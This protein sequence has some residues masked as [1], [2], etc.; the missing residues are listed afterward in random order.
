MSASAAARRASGLAALLLNLSLEH[1]SPAPCEEDLQR[2]AR[3]QMHDP[4]NGTGPTRLVAGAEAGAVVA[5][6]VL[7]E[8]EVVAPVRVLLKLAAAPVDRP[9]A[10]LVSQE[11]TGQPTRDL[12]GDLIQRH[13]PP[14]ARGTFDGEL[15]A[16]VPVIVQQDPDD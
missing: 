4:G 14:G 13:L 7:V 1:G 6:K 5:V 16:I 10:S 3:K 8:Q 11:D 12:L 9:P 15:V 2:E